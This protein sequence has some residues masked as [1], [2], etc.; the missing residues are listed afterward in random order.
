MDEVSINNKLDGGVAEQVAVA[1]FFNHRL[2]EP[3]HFY[4]RTKSNDKFPYFS[5]LPD[6]FRITATQ[7]QRGKQ[8]PAFEFLVFLF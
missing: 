8:P 7:I 6:I 2:A 5:R 1:E 3:F 4:K